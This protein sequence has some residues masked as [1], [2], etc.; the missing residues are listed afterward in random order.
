MRTTIYLVRHGE[1]AGNRVLRYQPYNTPLSEAGEA[2]ARLVAERLT[3]E[4]PFAALYASDLTR[5]L[6]TAS[7]IGA[8]LGLE[9]IPEPRLRELDTGDWKGSLYEEI[10]ARFPGHR[11]RWLAGGGLERLPG[12]SGESSSD[13]YRRVTAAFDALVARHRGE[14]VIAVSHG[15]ALSILL[16]SI[17]NWDY[18]AAFRDQRIRLRNTAVTIVEVD[19]AGTRRCTLLNCIRHLPASAPSSVPSSATSDG[20]P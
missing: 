20:S 16:A 2:Q 5:T 4:A 7:A 15:W 12:A 14:R 10:E 1:T 13:V 18:A 3:G 11:D 9:P 6:Q 17:H 8:R 19:A